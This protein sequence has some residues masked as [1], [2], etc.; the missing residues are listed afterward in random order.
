M[1]T[2][3]TTRPEPLAHPTPRPRPGTRRGRTPTHPSC[4]S[5]P[6]AF[7][8]Q[9]RRD[10]QLALG[11]STRRKSAWRGPG[12]AILPR[13]G[14]EVGGRGRPQYLSGGAPLASAFSSRFFPESGK[15]GLRGRKRKRGLVLVM[16]PCSAR[17]GLSPTRGGGDAYLWV[18][19]PWR[20]SL[21]GDSP[22]RGSGAVRSR[23]GLGREAPDRERDPDSE[24][25]DP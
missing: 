11:L 16:L 14:S 13:G 15:A 21:F 9:L 19:G 12:A 22:R 7:R 17:E 20:P 3:G 6:R 10:T 18:L 2:P 4:G 1:A 5:T 23:L 25:G 24:S 8:L